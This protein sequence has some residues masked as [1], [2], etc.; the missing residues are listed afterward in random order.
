VGTTSPWP[1]AWADFG[2]SPWA[3]KPAP[4]FAQPLVHEDTNWASTPSMLPSPASPW[5][6]EA[7]AWPTHLGGRL[8]PP[9]SPWPSLWDPG[10]GGMGCTV[11]CAQQAVAGCGTAAWAGAWDA[12]TGDGQGL[13]PAGFQAGSQRSSPLAPMPDNVPTPALLSPGT[14]RWEPRCIDVS[15][16]VQVV[17][18]TSF[19]NCTASAPGGQ[20]TQ[21]VWQPVDLQE[22]LNVAVIGTG[23]SAVRLR[24]GVLDERVV[25]KRM[26]AGPAAWPAAVATEPLML[27]PCGRITTSGQGTSGQ[28]GAE[29]AGD[30]Y[31]AYSHC[32][33]GTLAEWI[34]AQ[35]AAGRQ[36]TAEQSSRILVGVVHAAALFLASGMDVSAICADEIFIDS[37]EAPRVRLRH[38]VAPLAGSVWVPARGGDSAKWLAPEEVAAGAAAGWPAAAFRAGLILYCLGASMP[39]PY[40]HTRGEL[41]LLD[42]KREVTGTGRAV[43]PDP[44]QYHGAKPLKELMEACLSPQV[45]RRPC[46][47][48]MMKALECLIE[49]VV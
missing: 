14:D 16:L 31:L 36:P 11:D 6:E 47:Q 10:F 22:H 49:P 42:L 24:Y 32:Q 30:C 34:L 4:G 33:H 8:T 41:V 43:R 23:K 21:E 28:N 27:A 26:V 18:S 3:S 39:D 40:P 17:E 15:C 12:R 1:S 44:S 29:E 13:H 48:K 7:P 37:T 2:E 25:V 5:S 35:R 19:A 45:S 38:D 46:Q 20:S 9:A